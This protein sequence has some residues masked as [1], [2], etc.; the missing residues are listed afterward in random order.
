[1]SPALIDFLF[2][3][4]MILI[5]FILGLGGELQ[6]MKMKSSTSLKYDQEFAFKVKLGLIS[7]IVLI[8]ALSML[9]TVWGFISVFFG[10][11]AVYI[12]DKAYI[13]FKKDKEQRKA[14]QHLKEMEKIEDEID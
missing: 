6:V 5:N 2:T 10:F 14:Q 9:W 3:L 12:G 11:G 13:V 8:S 1:M 4:L 7:L